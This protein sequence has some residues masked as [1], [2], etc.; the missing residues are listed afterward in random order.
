[1]NR[2]LLKE[3]NSKRTA[4]IFIKRISHL[5]H[6][7][8]DQ[9]IIDLATGPKSIFLTDIMKGT[10]RYV[11]CK[12]C[13]VNKASVNLDCVI[14]LSYDMWQQTKNEIMDKCEQLL[15]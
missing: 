8:M 9:Y 6:Y 11:L 5:Q 13:S 10:K 1:M 14:E 4:E 7:C 12:V 3:I 15:A 2:S